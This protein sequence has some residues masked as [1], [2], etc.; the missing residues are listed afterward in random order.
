MSIA[1]SLGPRL[2]RAFAVSESGSTLRTEARAGLTTFLTMSYILLVNPDI[3]RH[4]IPVPDAFAQL[5]FSTAA[6]A[7]VGCILM[8]VVAR[9]PYAQAPGMGLN[10]YFTFTVVLGQK[11]PWQVALGSVFVGGLV[12]SALSVGGVRQAIVGALPRNLKLAIT[13]GIGLFLALIGLK[14]GG[15]VVAHPATLLTLGDV[16]RPQTLLALFGLLLSGALLSRRVPGAILYGIAATTL[17]A[18]LLKAPVYPG[19]GAELRPFPGLGG[20]A[21]RLPVWPRDLLLALDVRGA[22]RFGVLGVLFT[23]LFVA[24]FDTAGTLIGL[25]ARAGFLDERGQLPRANRAFLSDAI[26]TSIGAALGTSSTTCYIES[27]AGIS[28]GGRTGLTAVVTGLLFALSVFLWPL[29]AAVPAAATAPAL[30]LVGSLMMSN[31]SEVTWDD[32][33]EALPV[34]LTVCGMPFTFSIAN[35]VALGVVSYVLLKAAGGRARE[36]SPVLA[37]LAALLMARYAWLGE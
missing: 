21:L 11:I 35:G 23:F 33:L 8:G 15:L 20:P 22:L 17:L 37:I 24:I 31:L 18:I 12:F 7:A 2:D 29:C 13:A 1:A 16:T 28:E 14:N 25:S 36:V 30:I 10:A 26:T 19:A 5:L 3:L 4:A 34:F 27:A 32:P 6:A 9:Y